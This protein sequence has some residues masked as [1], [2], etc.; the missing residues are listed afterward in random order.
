M[1]NITW[2]E[3]NVGIHPSKVRKDI[4]NKGNIISGRGIFQ[5]IKV[6]FALHMSESVVPKNYF[7]IK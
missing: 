3:Y 4:E 7:T 5:E 6:D 2:K 1:K